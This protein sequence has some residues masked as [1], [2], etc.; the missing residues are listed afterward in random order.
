MSSLPPVPTSGPLAILG[1]TLIDGTGHDPIENAA[2]VIEGARIRAIGP[3]AAVSLPPNATVI[4]AQGKTLL[5]GL[6][7]CHVH[8]GF[9]SGFNLMRRIT[10]PPSLNIM[11][12]VP[13]CRATLEGGITTVRD[14]GGTPAGVKLAVE[15]GL[16]PG[17][18]ML[19]AVTIISQTGG[20]GDGYMP[21]CVDL[22]LG[23]FPD[24]PHGVVDG[25]EEVRKKTREILRAGADWVKLCTSGG[26][27]SLGDAPS[28]PQLTVEEIAAAVY[29]AKMQH[30]RC[31]AHAQA[32][33][34]IKNALRAGIASIEHGIWL[35]DEAIE[36]MK[37]QGVYLVPTLVAPLDVIAEAE[38]N[39]NAMP[40]WAV[41]KARMVAADHQA[42]FRKAVQAGVKIAMGTDTGVGPHGRNARELGLMVENG[43]TPMQSIVASTSEA[44]TL[45]HLDQE[46]G[47]LEEG[48]LAD[49]LLLDGD[50]LTTIQLV[51]DQGKLDLIMK[52]GQIVKSQLEASKRSAIA[53][54]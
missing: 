22:R 20:H 12:A 24:V 6:I 42:S 29:E 40:P 54:V 30:K 51:E 37:K 9:Q 28:S 32:T 26:V 8:I 49:L 45:L 2:I 50:P 44:A 43:M 47:T 53:S 31:M 3:R 33:D 5:P 10:T 16:F 41:E 46:I 17:P 25:V 36:M 23:N 34:G 52:A 27:L 35:D 11:H 13:N 19:V 39:P 1:A 4:E 15:R 14:A 38:A 18:R 21:C 7:D 48:K